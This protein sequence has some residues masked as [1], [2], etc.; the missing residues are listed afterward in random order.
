[1][2][3]AADFAIKAQSQAIQR[4]EDRQPSKLALLKILRAKEVGVAG[5]NYHLTLLVKQ[6]GS[7]RTA[8]AIV[9]WQPWRSDPYRLTSW[10]WK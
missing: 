2:I 6:G 7:D 9:W 4:L 5:I 10:N 1:L 8:E 3:T